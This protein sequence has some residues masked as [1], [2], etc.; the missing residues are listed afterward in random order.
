MR[1][2]P[3][4][5][6]LAALLIATV[7]WLPAIQCFFSRDPDTLVPKLT[8]RQL[9]F[10][11]RSSPE[12]RKLL[13]DSN[14]EWDLMGRTFTVLAFANLAIREPQN[15]SRYLSII[16]TIIADTDAVSVERG[17]EYFLMAYARRGRFQDA[18]ARSMFLEGETALMIAARQLVEP[19]AV[20]R[21]ALRERVERIVAQ[22]ERGP[23]LSGES[24]PDEA[25]TFC[26]AVALAAIR[27]FDVIEG[28]DHSALFARW[29]EMAKAHLIDPNTGLLVSSYTW[30]GQHLDGPEGS[31]IW[32]VAHALSIIDED[33]ARDQYRR[34]K[35][36]LAVEVLG[37]GYA[38]EWPASWSGRDDIDSGPTIPILGANA[39]ASGLALVGAGAFQ[40]R[41]Y[42]EALVASL[43]FAAFPIEDDRTLRYA[44]A[45]QLGDAVLLYALVS[46]PLFDRVRE[47]Q[48]DRS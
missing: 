26:N 35:S 6:K 40:D 44:A 5:A 12:D 1:T 2:R 13:R 43:D 11:E 29:M 39:G 33:F 41:P 20:H 27:I 24:Y 21:H 28:E 15:R 8:A 9:D 25:W 22:L 16:D 37:F 36:E 4:H 48:G 19:S 7:L 17:Q 31:S 42:L 32:L 34:A 18:A 45:N 14:A 46:G 10:W 47:T 30:R 38:R 23:R 3:K